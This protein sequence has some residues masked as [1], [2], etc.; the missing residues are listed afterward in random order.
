MSESSTHSHHYHRRL[1]SLQ[2]QLL[3]QDVVVLSDPHD[4]TYFTGFATLT[5]FEREAFCI[6]TQRSATLLLSA[7]SSNQPVDGLTIESFSQ[8]RSVGEF[9][10]QRLGNNTST[11]LFLDG[12]TL[13]MKEYNLL[14]HDLSPS[15]MLPT[16]HPAITILRQHKDQAEITALRQANILTHRAIQQAATSLRPGMTEQDVQDLVEKTLRTRPSTPL[17]FPTIVAF[18][19]NSAKPHHQPTDR[20]LIENEP[21]LIDCGAT[22]D[23]YCADVTRTLWFGDTPDSVFITIEK[24]VQQAYA[25]TLETLT[26]YL[27]TPTTGRQADDVHPTSNC[28]AQDLDHTCRSYIEQQGYGDQFIHT[29]GHGVGLYIHETPSISSRDETTLEPT[30]VITIEPGIYIKGKYGYRFENSILITEDGYEEL[31]V[32]G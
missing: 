16:K 2:S 6:I 7:F 17:A 27:S 12:S 31:G 4:L 25:Q 24:V 15:Q 1:S 32:G 9:I 13:S 10:R 30:M 8:L 23:G 19:E 26:S 14:S 28:K 21:V 18:G 3:D 20:K 5:P 11:R 22:V 29:T